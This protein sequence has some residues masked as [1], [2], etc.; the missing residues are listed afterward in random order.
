MSLFTVVD[1]DQGLNVC[2]ALLE[3][4]GT[5]HTA[6][7]HTANSALVNRFATT[8]RASRLLVNSPATQGL[9]GLTTGLVPSL[10]LGAGTWGGS[11]TTNSV[12]YKDLL[13]I[14]RI[15]YYT[16]AHTE[17]DR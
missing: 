14:K 15:A 11:S 3:I 2:S 5:G 4:D 13:N 6:I 12:T 1:M 8:I 17:E 10:T 7:I 9:L 16:S